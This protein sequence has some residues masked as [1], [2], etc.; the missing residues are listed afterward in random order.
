MQVAP[1][2]PGCKLRHCTAAPAHDCSVH[3]H[4]MSLALFVSLQAGCVHHPLVPVE[5][6][7]FYAAQGCPWS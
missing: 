6:P 2:F 4:A 3:F 7:L 1:L 5:P